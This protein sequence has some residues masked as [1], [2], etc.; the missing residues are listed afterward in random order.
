MRTPCFACALLIGLWVSTPS[1]LQTTECSPSKV[2]HE[3][4]QFGTEPDQGRDT[5]YDFILRQ[6]NSNNVDCGRWVEQHR[7]EF[8]ELCLQNP[9]FLYSFSITIALLLAAVVCVKQR[10]D[11]HRRMWITAEMM[12][13]LYNQDSYSRQ[14]AEE[15]IERYNSHIERCNRAVEVG[16]HSGVAVASNEIEQ[17]RAELMH[18]AEE[19]DTAIRDRDIAREDLRRKSEILADLSVRMDTA[20][21]KGISQSSAKG[22][23]G[24]RSSDARLVTHINNLQEQLYVERTSNRR[25]KGG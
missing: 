2:W 22:A 19:R 12:A 8:V 9:Y 21:N 6:F 5:W 25:L 11:H 16:N 7:R 23:S 18:V 17:L 20:T 13:D 24:A 10:I 14:I 1:G 4:P 15:A 3:T